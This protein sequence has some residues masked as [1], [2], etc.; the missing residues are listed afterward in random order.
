M[1]DYSAHH[2]AMLKLSGCDF[3]AGDLVRVQQLGTCEIIALLPTGLQVRSQN[4]K[5]C[6]V[7]RHICQKVELSTIL[8][9]STYIDMHSEIELQLQ[10]IELPE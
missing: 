6:I 5:L 3:T 8:R 9:N 10:E 4:G 1:N 2:A 7:S